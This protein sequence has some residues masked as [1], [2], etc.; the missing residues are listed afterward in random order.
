MYPDLAHLGPLTIHSYGVALALAFLVTVGLAC[1]IARGPFG[2]KLPLDE[3]ALV[4]WA[5]WT[6]AGGI[7]GGR[8]MYVALNWEL[9]AAE[10]QEMIAVWHGGLVWYGGFLGGLLATLI[11]LR[12]RRVQLLRGLDQVMPV[13]ALGH[14]IGRMGCF[15]NGCCLGVPTTAWFGVRFPGIAQPLIP[16]QLFES[17]GLVLLYVFL[18]RLQTPAML[19]RTG[20]IFGSYLAGYGFLRWALEYWRAN[21]PSVWPGL[22]LQQVI[23]LAVVVI[24]VGLV[25]RSLI[26]RRVGQTTGIE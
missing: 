6:M 11:F 20:T 16:V 17:A 18:R 25:L 2:A 7:V 14:A 10:P 1:H 22:T 4:D 12:S 21:Q 9:Y 26:L 24:G 13:V 23:S 19:E 5:C 3:T 15:L 8:V